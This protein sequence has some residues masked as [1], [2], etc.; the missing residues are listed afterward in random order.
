[1]SI[2][3]MQPSQFV[4]ISSMSQ[5]GNIG[6]VYDITQLSADFKTKG[7]CNMTSSPIQVRKLTSKVTFK[8]ATVYFVWT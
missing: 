4:T 3:G 2:V 1:M 7:E 8:T 6:G 5:A